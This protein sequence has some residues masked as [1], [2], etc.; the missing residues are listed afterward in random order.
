MLLLV[1]AT[2]K[3]SYRKKKMEVE[4]PESPDWD[5]TEEEPEVESCRV[6][7][8]E[9]E[10]PEEED[11]S[12][13]VRRRNTV[14]HRPVGAEGSAEPSAPAPAQSQQGLPASAIRKT[15]LLPFPPG[16][17]PVERE[18]EENRTLR[19][20]EEPRCDRAGTCNRDDRDERRSSSSS[21]HGASLKLGKRPRNREAQKK[22]NQRAA[23]NRAA[24]ERDAATAMPT[25]PE[26]VLP[27][28]VRSEYRYVAGRAEST[29]AAS[30][31]ISRLSTPGSRYLLRYRDRSLLISYL[32]SPRRDLDTYSDIETVVSLSHISAL[33]AGI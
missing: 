20:R 1:V 10:E 23:R 30:Y 32:G 16:A 31:L 4:I 11:L 6:S 14:Q 9:E 29:E 26:S 18:R 24:R 15:I 7:Q 13:A 17:G 28:H 22:K 33:H 5:V 8:G 25:A 27:Q 21:S 3:E 19:D 2:R 12:L